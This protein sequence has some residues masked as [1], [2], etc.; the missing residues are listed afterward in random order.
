MKEKIIS[1]LTKNLLVGKRLTSSIETIV[2]KLQKG[3]VPDSHEFASLIAAL[4]KRFTR[5]WIFPILISFIPIILLYNQNQLIRKQTDFFKSQFVFESQMINSQILFDRYGNSAMKE[6]ALDN[7]IKSFEEKSSYQ[8]NL[9]GVKL[10]DTKLVSKDFENFDFSSANMD[11]VD[12]SKSNFSFVTFDKSSM[13]SSKFQDSKFNS[14]SFRYVRFGIENFFINEKTGEINPSGGEIYLQKHNFRNA[15]F[16]NCV[17]D[18]VS[19]KNCDFRGATFNNLIWNIESIIPENVA[20]SIFIDVD[21]LSS[22]IITHL[23]KARAILSKSDL[24]NKIKRLSKYL[25]SEVLTAQEI[26][27]LKLSIQF[28]EDILSQF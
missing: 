26:V 11:R 28:Y 10:N 13:I 1:V 18:Q 7:F 27:K 23:K 14:C 6:F 5:I 21:G 3:N 12:A 15:V 17:F 2:T 25:T 24:E 16:N 19:I 4:I 9:I 22:E 20:G 8:K